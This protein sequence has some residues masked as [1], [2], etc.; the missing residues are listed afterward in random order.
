MS[1]PVPPDLL[2]HGGSEKPS[3]ERVLDAQVREARGA[4]IRAKKAEAEPVR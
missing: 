1:P 4:W 2:E 3:V